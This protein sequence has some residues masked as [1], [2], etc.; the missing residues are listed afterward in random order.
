MFLR[1]RRLKYLFLRWRRLKYMFPRRG[2]RIL[3]ID[4]RRFAGIVAILLLLTAAAPVMACLT[5]VVMSGE[6]SACCR[7][8][9]GQCGRMEK[10]GCCRTEVRTDESPQIAVAPPATDVQWICIAHLPALAAPVHFAASAVW[11][12]PAEHSPP[13]LVTTKITV[14]RI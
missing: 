13:G 6:E 8:M 9:H 3:G 5:N 4:M 14:L 12:M 7:A 11:L 1:W 10:M 2:G